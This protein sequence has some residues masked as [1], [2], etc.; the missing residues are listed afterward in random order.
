MPL[1]NPTS[2]SS[3]SVTY[4]YGTGSAG[5]VVNAGTVTL[6]TTMQY[7]SLSI[8]VATVLA[9]A[10]WQALSKTTAQIDGTF[11]CDGANGNGTL[12]GA[13]AAGQFN[14]GSGGAG[15]LNAGSNATNN[16]GC[17]GAAGGAGGTGNSGGNAGGTGGTATAPTAINAVANENELA[18]MPVTLS[19]SG[20]I[21]LI[22]GSGG[23]GGGGDGATLT[24]RGGGGGGGIL[25]G[26]FRFLTVT[27]TC[28]AIGGNGATSVQG[29]GGGGGG[30]AIMFFYDTISDG[31]ATYSTAKGTGGAGVGTGGNGVDGTNGAAKWTP[32]KTKKAA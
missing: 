14:S 18:F 3:E 23:G 32:F 25:Q 16:T 8:P 13:G 9:T 15:G 11:S 22:G 17:I 4:M 28:R 29:G 24:G 27:G 26:I 19:R 12:G 6:T 21:P 5:D 7:N 31:G 10:G 2:G 20:M 30:G 1:Y